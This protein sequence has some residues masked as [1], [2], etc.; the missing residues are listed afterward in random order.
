MAELVEP[1][2]RP[3]TKLAPCN[4]SVILRTIKSEHMCSKNTTICGSYLKHHVFCKSWKNWVLSKSDFFF[5][6]SIGNFEFLTVLLAKPSNK[7]NCLDLLLAKLHAYGV[8][9][10]SLKLLLV[11]Y[12]RIRYQ[13]TKVNGKY[14]SWEELLTG[15]PQGSVLGP[16]LLIYNLT[17]YY[18]L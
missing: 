6:Y 9:N 3:L 13:R 18:M 15:V 12:L 7:L 10:N 14:S 16:S 5:T 17:I 11:S 1:S 8:S 2:A 4:A